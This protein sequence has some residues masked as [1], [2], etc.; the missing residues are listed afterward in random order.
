[1]SYFDIHEVTKIYDKTTVLDR[2]SLSFEKGE[3]IT[4][5]GPSG[6]G[7]STLL[8]CIAGLTPV[9][10]GTIHMD[11]K[12]ITHISSKDREV[13]MVFQSYALFPNMTAFENIVFGLKM[14]RLE[15][16]EV[17]DKANRIIELVH[18][19]GKEDSY[20]HQLSGGQQQRVALARSLVMEPKVL[21]LDEPLSALDAKIRKMLQTE[22]RKIQQDL[23]ITTIFVTHDQEEAL[24][25]SDKVYVMEN[26]EIIQWGTPEQIYTSPANEFVANFIGNYNVLSAE[27]LQQ[28][29]ENQIEGI[30]FAIRP[31][32]IQ[33]HPIDSDTSAFSDNVWIRKGTVEEVTMK[34]NILR[35]KIEAN[36]ISLLI[37]QLHQQNRRWNIGTIVHVIIPK[38]ECVTL[39]PSRKEAK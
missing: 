36:G 35:Y 15:K 32:V 39:Q 8:R 34:G 23:E 13:G 20:P 38:S 30:S 25:L 19:T 10:H 6:C 29:V 33:L 24:T 37:D 21:L 5:L 11:D 28:L 26:G 18:L 16:T 12:D 22:L 31:E 17:R 1:M 3:L 9:E 27:E 2:V 7:K 4:L 14:K